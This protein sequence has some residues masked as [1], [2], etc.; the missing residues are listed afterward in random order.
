MPI[1]SITNQK[2]GVGK[3]TTAVNLASCLA[4]SGL[5]VLL[6][7]IDPQGNATTSLGFVRQ[8][9]HISTYEILLDRINPLA[10]M[11]S[12]VQEN[13]FL[14]PANDNL[15]G[16]EI[17]LADHP[18]RAYLLRWAL[19]DLKPNFDFIFI[20]CPPSL[21]LLTLNGLSAAEGIL[22]PIQA[23]FLALDGLSQLLKTVEIVKNR[24]NPDLIILGI[25]LTMFDNRTRLAREV[26][27]SLRNY[28]KEDSIVFNTAIP[29]SVRLA[30]APSH[31]L[32]INIYSPDSIGANSFKHLAEE[33]INASETRFG[34]RAGRSDPAI[35]IKI[36]NSSGREAESGKPGWNM[37]SGSA[38]LEN[39][40]QPEPA[41]KDIC[42]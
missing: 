36:C 6:V 28:F 35:D 23:E 41:A 30:E 26:E 39:T 8:E 27:E 7:D 9:I 22:I 17:E 42:G 40:S 1:L 3:T 21:G 38:C 19:M 31:G 20:D 10:A 25:I 29:R 37:D 11:Q 32:P 13:L 33:V 5:R 18:N 24:L 16:A 4:Q 34:K 2:G 14:I 15:P 12:T